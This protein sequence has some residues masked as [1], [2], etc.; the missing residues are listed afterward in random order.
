MR[1][2]GNLPGTC[3]VRSEQ[4]HY[5]LVGA[6]PE[7][8][9]VLWTEIA[10]DLQLSNRHTD[11]LQALS[12]ADEQLREALT[13]EGLALLYKQRAFLLDC[14]GQ[15]AEAGAQIERARALA[16]AENPAHHL[17]EVV[18]HRLTLQRGLLASERERALASAG[19]DGGVLSAAKS[20]ANAQATAQVAELGRYLI[21]KGPW[22]HV[23]Q[24][25]HHY[26]PGITA[27]PW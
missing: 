9:L 25:P 18:R 26:V 16:E 11:A 24:L 10:T 4:Y 14:N 23:G 7:S 21:Q 13:V 2:R 20:Q 19:D 22:L 1:C 8:Y 6:I 3:N 12:Q 5:Y 15:Y 17:D 27:L